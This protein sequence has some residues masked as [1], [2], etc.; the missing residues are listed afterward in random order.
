MAKTYPSGTVISGKNAGYNI[1]V[2]K[3]LTSN[4]SDLGICNKEFIYD[5][6]VQLG[7]RLSW[8]DLKKIEIRSVEDKPADYADAAAAAII[9]GPILG[10]A[11]HESS[12]DKIYTAAITYKDDSRSLIKV[13]SSVFA[14]LNKWIFD[15]EEREREN[16]RF[17]NLSEEEKQAE[18]EKSQDAFREKF[19]QQALKSTDLKEKINLLT[20]IP[21][22]KDAEILKTK[23]SQMLKEESEKQKDS[24]YAEYLEA[25]KIYDKASD[26]AGYEKALESFKKLSDL[27]YED[28]KYLYSSIY[29]ELQSKKKERDYNDALKL[30]GGNASDIKKAIRLFE[31]LGAYKDSKAKLEEATDKLKTAK[32]SFFCFFK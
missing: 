8:Y 28:S 10:Y 19:Y 26:I 5:G 17:N 11:V 4:Q 7:D 16:T 14:V 6:N 27:D 1:F 12:K 29:R 31:D 13:N 18:R 25:V 30:M 22:Y 21:G 32:K 23:Y 24:L 3:G 2:T 9:G 15:I 20:K